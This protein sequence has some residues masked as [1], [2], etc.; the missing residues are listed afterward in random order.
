MSSD[1]IYLM[2]LS[3][4]G[5]AIIMIIVYIR[6]IR[7]KISSGLEIKDLYKK[8][9]KEVESRR[10]AEEKLSTEVVI[11]HEKIE[12]LLR[13]ID[14]LR[15][16]KEIEV[17][18]RLEA[19]KQI[20]IALQ[21]TTELQQRM[22]DWSIVQNAAMKDSKEAII[23]VGNDLY[24]KLNDSYKSEVETS[25]NLIGRVSQ[26]ISEFFSKASNQ[27]T[28]QI[29][30]EIKDKNK[31]EKKAIISAT[32]SKTAFDQISSNT[33]KIIVDF[34]ETMKISG[35]S[36]NKDYFLSSNFEEK[37]SKLFLCET[38]LIKEKKLHIIDFKSIHYFEEYQIHKNQNKDLAQKI[39]KQ[40]LDK[41]LSYLSNQKYC[42][43]IM[44]ATVLNKV[45][46]NNHQIIM[47]LANKSDLQVINEIRYYTKAINLKILVLDIDELTN[48]VL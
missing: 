39:L 47:A 10:I 33:K 27:K 19:E 34:V 35:L 23:K 32:P 31:V 28:I 21:K 14:E 43:S 3:N 30:S 16:S 42:D 1:A 15:K 20:E 6:Y 41:Y 8:I 11:D 44:Q 36:V 40:K 9:D 38:A 26:N 13:E 4:I 25:K 2:I 18:L 46:F 5:L 24:K 22:K 37:K 7:F 17:R 12:N 48:L 45:K 29:S